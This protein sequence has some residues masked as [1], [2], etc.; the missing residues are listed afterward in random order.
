MMTDMIMTM[1]EI[2]FPALKR[3]V[4]T[5]NVM[6]Y[7]KFAGYTRNFNEGTLKFRKSRD[8]N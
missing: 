1:T 7:N 3:T 6:V 5:N 4:Y 2:R 8:R